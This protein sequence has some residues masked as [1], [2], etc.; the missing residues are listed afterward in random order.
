VVKC[1]AKIFLDKP[2]PS[3]YFI[4]QASS[5]ILLKDEYSTLNFGILTSKKI[6]SA[7]SGSKEMCIN[8]SQHDTLATKNKLGRDFA[9]K[10][11]QTFWHWNFLVTGAIFGFGNSLFGVRVVGLF[12]YSPKY[13][14]GVR[15][16][17]ILRFIVSPLFDTSPST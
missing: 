4:V 15:G 9:C 7:F 5:Q 17:Y 11:V 16:F 14:Q 13:T 2:L 12:F 6:A 3:T 1:D 10:L 8:L